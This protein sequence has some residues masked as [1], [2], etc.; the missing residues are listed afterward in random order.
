MSLISL[1]R[2][3]KLEPNPRGEE[4]FLFINALNEWGEGNTL[5]PSVQWGDGFSKALRS[6]VDYAEE[7]LPWVDEVMRRGEQLE[8]EVAD[9]DSEV[10]VCVIVRDQTGAYPWSQPWQLSDTL[11]SLQA[12][13][14]P[15]WRA[16][17]LPVGEATNIRGI[18]VHVMDT[19]DPRILATDIPIEVRTTEG[20]NTTDGTTDWVIAALDELD[21]SCAKAKYMLVTDSSTQYEPHAFDVAAEK[22]TDIIGLNYVSQATMALQD[23]RAGPMSWGERCTRYSKATPLDLCEAMVPNKDDLLDLSA[24]LI[25]LPRWRAED[26]KFQEAATTF[27]TGNSAHILP[28][29]WLRRNL[30]WD[31]EVPSSGQCDVIRAGTYQACTQKGHIWYDGPDVEGFQSGC[32]SGLGLQYSFGDENITTDWDYMRFKNEDPFCARLSETMYEDVSA[33][34][35][36]PWVPGVGRNKEVQEGDGAGE[37]EASGGETEAE[38]V[39]VE[40]NQ[41]K[42]EEGVG[43]ESQD[44]DKESE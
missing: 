19:Y 14:N 18:A 35:V 7:H 31:W 28:A 8:P 21:P 6:A 17:V 23:A 27:G 24:A 42:E 20:D 13:H 25:N 39:D 11:W 10:D 30:P 4:N 34:K 2:R 38:A 41:V 5:E 22:E 9:V 15:R 1:I 44:E 29:L 32:H 37:E 12:Q 40:E 16:L 33:G 26:H 36:E 43:G 3:I